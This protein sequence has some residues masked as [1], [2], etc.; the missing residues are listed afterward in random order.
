MR[1][2]NNRILVRVNINQKDEMLVG[3]VLIKTALSFD[4]N[5]R[6][7]SPVIAE[8]V[9][10]N[11]VLKQGDII[12][13]HHNHFYAPSPYYL[14]D[15]LY[16]IPFNKTIFA[17]VSKSGNLTAICGNVLGDRVTIKEDLL[18]PPE[19]RKSYV[20]RLLVTDKGWTTY[21]NGTTVICRPNAPY[22]IVYN[23]GGV[24]KRK[25]KLDSDMICGFLN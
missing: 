24:E 4:A 1:T 2:V 5:Y 20:D 17:K 9:E 13:C 23:W 21:K 22:D 15:D 25:T 11:N 14:Q 19:F 12:V 16:S 10:G 7:R 6:E 3:G 8:V 18:L